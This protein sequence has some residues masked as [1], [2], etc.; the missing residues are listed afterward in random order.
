MVSRVQRHG[1]KGFTLIELM[2][3]VAIIGIIIAIAVPY[4]VGYKRGTCDQAAAADISKLGASIE[5]F[6]AELTQLRAP[7][8][9]EMAAKTEFKMAY[10]VGPYYGWGGTNDSC[11][12][13]ANFNATDNVFEA[14]AEKGSKPDKTDATKRYTYKV[15]LL[16]GAPLAPT[17][18][19]IGSDWT[20]YGGAGQ[21]CYTSSMIDPAAPND[22]Q[23]P[24]SINCESL[25][26]Q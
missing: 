16:G 4:Y 11:K 1:E 12:V 24:G 9:S 22:V 7:D 8:V 21:L 5:R 26:S 13:K 3:V 19:V 15:S 18:G 17:V 14:A 25:V 2:V 23:T 6:G 20:G 10:L